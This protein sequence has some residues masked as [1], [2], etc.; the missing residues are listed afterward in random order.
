MEKG[1]GEDPVARESLLMGDSATQP[2]CLWC[3]RACYRHGCLECVRGADTRESRPSIW[4][5]G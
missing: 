1:R 3:S 5:H 4:G 2:R